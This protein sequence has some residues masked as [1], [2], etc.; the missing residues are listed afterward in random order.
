[1]LNKLCPNSGEKHLDTSARETH[2]RLEVVN[3]SA[4][5]EK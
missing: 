1:M 3:S 5:N 2:T 4:R